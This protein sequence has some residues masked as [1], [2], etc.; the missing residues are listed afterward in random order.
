MCPHINNNNKKTL[1]KDVKSINLIAAVSPSVFKYVK[2]Q[3][4]INM[5][6]P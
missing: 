3:K 1:E 6:L 2:L 5:T 4:R